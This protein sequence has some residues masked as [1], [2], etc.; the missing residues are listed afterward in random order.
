MTNLEVKLNGKTLSVAGMESLYGVMS[1][2]VMSNK[3]FGQDEEVTLDVSGLNT[4]TQA[5]LEWVSQNVVPGDEITIRIA[6]SNAG[7]YKPGVVTLE[8]M[9]AR[10]LEHKIKTYNRLKEELKDIL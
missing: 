2:I 10:D 9:E 1:V 6:E 8:D 7:T 3:K 4:E 5:R